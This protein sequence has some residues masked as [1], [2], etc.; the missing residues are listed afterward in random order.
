MVT[1]NSR[2]EGRRG[3]ILVL[4]HYLRST[5]SVLPAQS[6]FLPLLS[7]PCSQPPYAG[8]LHKAIYL[9]YI[10]SWLRVRVLT[11]NSII[12]RPGYIWSSTPLIY[13]ICVYLTRERSSS[14]MTISHSLSLSL[15]LRLPLFRCLVNLLRRYDQIATFSQFQV[16]LNN[17]LN[18]ETNDK[19]ITC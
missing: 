6:L 8:I 11:R 18:G 15:F 5:I 13:I 9:R 12:K 7:T 3:V 10:L 19:F 14:I 1:N 16:H 17:N 2:D 4:P